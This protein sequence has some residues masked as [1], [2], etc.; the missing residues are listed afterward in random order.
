MKKS[1]LIFFLFISKFLFAQGNLQFNQVI[2]LEVAT[3]VTSTTGTTKDSVEFIIPANKVWKIESVTATSSTS[4]NLNVNVCARLFVDDMFLYNGYPAS[5]PI[6]SLVSFP[7]WLPSGTHKFKIQMSGQVCGIN[8][9]QK[10]FLSV[11]EF[12]VVP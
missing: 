10:G 6:Y 2:N 8:T 9:I 7:F 5:G 11:I 1:I 3:T 12:N 4:N